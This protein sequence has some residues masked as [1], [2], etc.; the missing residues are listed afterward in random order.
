VLCE[1]PLALDAHDIDA[2]ASASQHQPL[3]LAE[4]YS[5]FLAPYYATLRALVADGRSLAHIDVRF[6]FH[7]TADHQIRFDAALGGGSFIDLGCYGV[8]LV[9]RLLGEPLEIVEVTATRLAGPLATFCLTGPVDGECMVRA[10]TASAPD[11]RI[12]TS[13]AAHRQQ[14]LQLAWQDGSAVTVPVAFR[15]DGPVSTVIEMTGAD[16]RSSV[17]SFPMF[18]ADLAMLRSVEHRIRDHEIPDAD[19]WKR[20]R[21]NAI[22]LESVRRRIGREWS[23]E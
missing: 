3:V 11:V 6:A 19:T 18:D 20:W 12:W 1:K 9:H 10:R 17:E 14:V 2:L 7:A 4:N 15:L 21:R 23:A 5:Y 16:G 8:D 22:A 13:F